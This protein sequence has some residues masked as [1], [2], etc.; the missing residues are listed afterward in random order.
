M[1]NELELAIANF[2]APFNPDTLADTLQ[3]LVNKL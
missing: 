3:S 2:A 1:K